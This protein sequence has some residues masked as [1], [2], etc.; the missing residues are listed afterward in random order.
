M[1]AEGNKWGLGVDMVLFPTCLDFSWKT[2]NLK[3]FARFL[4]F[5]EVLFW[6]ANSLGTSL[7]NLPEAQN[8][9]C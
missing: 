9:F 4:K 2:K 3:K 1:G 5:A 7:E 6:S 8:S